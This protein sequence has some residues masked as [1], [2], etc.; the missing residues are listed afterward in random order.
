M[1]MRWISAID[2]IW[3]RAN[4]F[5]LSSRNRQWNDRSGGNCN[6]SSGQFCKFQFNAI[7]RALDHSIF[8]CLE[9]VHSF[10]MLFPAASREKI[11]DGTIS[12]LKHVGESIVLFKRFECKTNANILLTAVIKPLCL[13]DV[14]PNEYLR[15]ICTQFRVVSRRDA[16]QNVNRFPAIHVDFISFVSFSVRWVWSLV[17]C[18][19]NNDRTISIV[20]DK[21]VAL[22]LWILLPLLLWWLCWKTKIQ[23]SVWQCSRV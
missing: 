3:I 21:S 8:L 14:S 9:S 10:S 15:F 19:M 7:N 6:L 11:Y 2:H 4:N 17:H 12:N 1:N 22:V 13:M 23:H 18:D 20:I 5:F 16:T